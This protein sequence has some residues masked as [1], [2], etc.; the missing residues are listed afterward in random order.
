MVGAS[1]GSWLVAALL[2]SRAAGGAMF[3]GM[4]GPLGAAVGTWLAVETVHRRNPVGVTRVLLV[5]FAAKMVFF[6]AYVAL[7]LTR[8]GS[9]AIPFAAS[10]TV[11]FIGLYGAEAA[12]LRRLTK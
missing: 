11:Y 2:T 3:L 9:S 12:M 8:I 5:G 4:I 7:V 1:V 10:F 6:G